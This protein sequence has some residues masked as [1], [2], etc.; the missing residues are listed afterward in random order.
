MRYCLNQKGVTLVELLVSF[1]IVAILAAGAFS[2]MVNVL[3]YNQ[4]LSSETQLRSEAD[5]IMSQIITDI[6]SA[7]N[8]AV[9]SEGD[10]LK[11]T[12]EDGQHFLLGFHNGNMVKSPVFSNPDSL[13]SEF[14]VLHDEKYTFQNED[15]FSTIE[16]NGNLIEVT[17]I[18]FDSSR[19]N[20]E[21]I[22]L[23]STISF[24]DYGGAD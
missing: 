21:G 23:Q 2:V 9:V 10:M 13:P 24:V 14:N 1:V 19:D 20:Q 17:M 7:E 12:K 16:L 22:Q 5:Y 11:I 4:K 18:M 6:Y 8:V 3:N 15:A